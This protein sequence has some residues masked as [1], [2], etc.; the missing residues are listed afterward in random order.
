MNQDSIQKL[1]TYFEQHP[2]VAMAFLF[3]SRS[4]REPGKIS[5]WDIAV[6]FT[7]DH[8][9][10]E[11][12]EQ[13][14]EYS[15]ELEIWDNLSKILETDNVDLIVLNRAAATI[16]ASAIQGIP[17]VIKNRKLYIEF[18][19]RA[20]QQAQD[21]RH[22][23]EEYAK[24]YWRSH[25]L[26]EEDKNIINKRLIFLDS[27]L[28]D[29]DKFRDLTQF[30]YEENRT[31]RREVERWVENL[32]NA[33]IDICKTILASEKHTVPSTYREVLQNI[34]L[35]PNFSKELSQQLANWSALRNI[36]AHEYLDIR[37]KQIE[38]FIK[39]SER[40]L[41]DFIKGVKEFTDHN[42]I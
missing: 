42:K 38:N 12:E 30:D 29:V 32:M 22:T 8:S 5:D 14:K 31:M 13:E 3:G 20:T 24:V 9:Q 26:S 15:G 4:K 41:R 21:Y 33:T 35:I 11:L 16:A 36:L 17:L 1:K 37:W 27:E 18:M 6:Y 39:N 28:R 19:L 2:D 34:A 7:P 25:S 40:Y 10:I 23:V